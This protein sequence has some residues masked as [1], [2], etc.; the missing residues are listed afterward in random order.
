MALQHVSAA[1]EA[2]ATMDDIRTMTAR[3]QLHK[4]KLIGSLKWLGAKTN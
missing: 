2:D 4:K 3:V 1:T